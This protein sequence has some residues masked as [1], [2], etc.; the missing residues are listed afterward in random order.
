MTDDGV[1]LRDESHVFP[2]LG[3]D[4]GVFVPQ[5]HGKRLAHLLFP[6]TFDDVVVGL[7][8]ASAQLAQ[9]NLLAKE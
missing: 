6:H 3:D 7:T 1:A 5:R 8:P 2:H 9:T 4:S